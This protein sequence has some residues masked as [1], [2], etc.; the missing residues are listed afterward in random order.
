MSLTPDEWR[1]KLSDEEHR[2]MR[3][4]G[5]ERP[6]SS[7]LNAEWRSGS[8]HCKGCG[9]ALFSSEAKFNSGCG[10]PSFDRETPEANITQV[11]DRSHGMV[12]IEV[13]CSKCDSHLGHVFP[14]GPTETGTRYC[15]NGVCLTFKPIG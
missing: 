11:V 15:I 10:W 12:R 2:V 1:A 6:Y 8:Y 13:R 7:E 9:T 3:E 4:S 14:D 5:T